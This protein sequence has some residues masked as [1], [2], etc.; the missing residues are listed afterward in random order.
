VVGLPASAWSLIAVSASATFGRTLIALVL[1]LWTVPA[2][3]AI[4]TSP[5]WS[6]RL[7]PIVQVVASIPAT[8]VFPAFVGALVGVAGGLNIAA[9]LL[10]LLGTQWYMLFNV[11]AG[12]MAIPSD[13]KEAALNYRVSGWR[14]WRTLILPAIFPYLVTGM[15]TATGGAWN[16]SIVSEYVL[17]A[18]KQLSTVGLGAVIARAAEHG[19]FALL[20]AATLVMAAIV[21]TGNRLVWRRMYRLAESRYR[22]G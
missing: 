17:F 16:A 14:R 2:G 6:R 4:G 1:A 15:I 12:A 7:Q 18:G 10:M 13:L 11:I 5:K 21:I 22:L 20:L 3:V 9:V 8:A 19:D